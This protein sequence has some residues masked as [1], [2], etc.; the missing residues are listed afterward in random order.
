MVVFCYIVGQR[1]SGGADDLD[2][3][4]STSGVSSSKYKLVCYPFVIDFMY[5]DVRVICIVRKLLELVGEH[6]RERDCLNALKFT[7]NICGCVLTIQG[8]CKDG[9]VFYWSSS[10]ELCSQNGSKVMKDNL[11]LAAA[12]VLSG[13]QFSKIKMMFRFAEI[14]WL[15]STSFHAYQ[16]HYICPVVNDYYLMEQVS[17]I[18]LNNVLKYFL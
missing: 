11:C 15:S 12:V 2:S 18:Y 13:N 1:N 17:C 8:S 7:T 4:L 6:C 3:G 5:I 16:R 14:A 10:E 9:H